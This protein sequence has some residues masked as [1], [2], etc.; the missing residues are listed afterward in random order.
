MTQP[1]DQKI[2]VRVRKEW[3]QPYFNCPET[4]NFKSLGWWEYHNEIEAAIIPQLKMAEDYLT[5]LLEA[6]FPEENLKDAKDHLW[7]AAGTISMLLC[8]TIKDFENL[9]GIVQFHQAIAE[10][11]E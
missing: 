7:E 9:F 8:K 11:T 10:R 5:T 1:V 3:L 6:G 2:T 4:D